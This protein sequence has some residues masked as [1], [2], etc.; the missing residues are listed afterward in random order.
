MYPPVVMDLRWVY[1]AD[2]DSMEYIRGVMAFVAMATS[3]N[4]VDTPDYL[5]CPCFD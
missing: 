1:E 5:W 4:S 3:T 2:R